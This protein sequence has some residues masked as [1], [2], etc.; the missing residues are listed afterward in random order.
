[1]NQPPSRV[2]YAWI[3]IGIIIFIVV[4]NLIVPKEH[5]SQSPQ[6]LHSSWQ[7]TQP[8]MFARRALAAVSANGYLY[9][10]GGVDETGEYVKQVEFAEI[11]PDGTLAPWR[12]T[13]AL[14]QGRFYL[15]A[16]AT[17]SHIYVL[18][19]GTGPLGDN[20]RPVATVEKA[21][22]LPDGSLGPWEYAAQMTTPRRGLKA[23]IVNNRAYA[24]GGYNGAFLKSTEHARI[25]SDDT[26]TG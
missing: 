11:L 4:L 21:A 6:P 25:L 26:L 9:A 17:E 5:T 19:G 15:A 7:F 10:L 24:I 16:V 8:M 18:G 23:A 13:T 22:I 2:S 14:N 20:N 12:Q 1:M 3:I